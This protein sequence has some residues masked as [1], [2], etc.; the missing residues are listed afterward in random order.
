LLQEI[1]VAVDVET[2]LDEPVP[3]DA[4]ESD[5]SVVLLELKVNGFAEVNI[6]ALNAMHVFSVHGELIEVE[7]LRKDLHVY[8]N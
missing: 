6:R 5:V 3:V 2:G 8:Y 7:V 4:L 1:E